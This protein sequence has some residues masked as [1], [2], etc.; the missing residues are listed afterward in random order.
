MAFILFLITIVS[1]WGIKIHSISVRI[2]QS[3]HRSF[4]N[5]PKLNA[6][7]TSVVYDTQ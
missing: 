7:N 6:L 5:Q 4:R 1:L 2:I 3:I